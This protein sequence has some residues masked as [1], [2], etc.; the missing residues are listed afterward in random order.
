MAEINSG[1]PII[2][3]PEAYEKL[4]FVLGSQQFSATTEIKPA[5]F[6]VVAVPTPITKEKKADLQ[7][8]YDAVRSISLVLQPGN[9]V[10]IESTVPVGAT[11]KIAYFIEEK[12][13][14]KAGVDFFISH[15]P[16]RVLPG[17]IF[18][19]LIANDRIIGGLNQ[20]SVEQTKLFYK[21]FVSG[22]FYLTSAQTAE[23][24]KLIENSSRDVQLAFAHQVSSM[25]TAIGLNP[26]EVISLANKHPRV[27]IL[28][29]T[30][31]VG[32]HC[33]AIDPW[34]LVESFPKHTQLIHAAREVNDAKPKEVISCITQAVYEWRK[35]NMGSCR[36]LL[37]GVSYKPNIEDLRE[38]PALTIAKHMVTDPT[39]QVS[40]SDPHVDRAVL[41]QLFG[42]RVVT[43]VDGLER[44]DIVAFLVAHDRFKLID[45]RLLDHKQ[46]F[47]FCG[48]LHES[49]SRAGDD[50][51]YWPARSVMD[52]F[53][54]NQTNED[55]DSP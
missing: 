55:V 27:N 34:F 24:V 53:I 7:H 26:Y 2:H 43:M 42:D 21:P 48:A 39:M 51:M 25:A 9:V 13:N 11:K 15:C 45:R 46:I 28:R 49:I 8:V 17:N 40:I 19:E 30:C 1:N 31:G 18:Y 54:A 35:Q 38:S 12:T 6:F 10:I 16:E 22:R 41:N 33:I 32:G 50:E 52:F 29:P 5:D 4:Q 3:E 14:L 47:D 23:M 20:E 37:L 36:L 44:A